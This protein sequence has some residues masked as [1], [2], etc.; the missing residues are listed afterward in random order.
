MGTKT[1][2]FATIPSYGILHGKCKVK[3][4]FMISE[5]LQ[6]LA[7]LGSAL[8]VYIFLRM[9]ARKESAEIREDM[10]NLKAEIK[11]LD[12]R[13]ISLENRVS[14]VE[15]RMGFIERLLEMVAGKGLKERTDP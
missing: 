10:K 5:N 12:S 1:L 2:H 7:T 8:A 3:R 11:T 4:K 6:I 9:G 15:T 14:V 13:I